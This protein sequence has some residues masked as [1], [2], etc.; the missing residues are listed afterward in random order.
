MALLYE[1][2]SI[3]RYAGVPDTWLRPGPLRPWPGGCGE[4][5]GFLPVLRDLRFWFAVWIKFVSC[6][7]SV[8]LAHTS[9][10]LT[11]APAFRC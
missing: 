9:P 3:R 7:V 1:V 2:E 11:L 6:S 8:F 4:W 5:L 10:F